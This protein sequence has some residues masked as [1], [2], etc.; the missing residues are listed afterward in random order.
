MSDD[1]RIEVLPVTEGSIIWLHNVDFPDGD[2]GHLVKMLREKIG[3]DRF[4]LLSTDGDGVV[5]MLGEDEVVARVRAALNRVLCTFCGETVDA[6]DLDIPSDDAAL[7]QRNLPCG[8]IVEQEPAL[9]VWGCFRTVGVNRVRHQPHD[10]VQGDL[11]QIRCHCPG[12]SEPSP[13]S[14]EADLDWLENGP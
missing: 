3:H 6:V 5:E 7:L 2:L 1:T 4:L 14:V 9:P 13:A 12:Y 10:W 11:K 8:H